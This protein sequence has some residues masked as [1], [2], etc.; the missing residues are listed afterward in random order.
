MSVFP[1][2]LQSTETQFL[3]CVFVPDGVYKDHIPVLLPSQIFPPV[4]VATKL[5]PL[6][7]IATELQFKLVGNAFTDH[8]VPESL[9]VHTFP[10]YM[11]AAKF[12]P[13]ESLARA[14]HRPVVG[15]PLTRAH[16]E[17]DPPTILPRYIAPPY[18]AAIKFPPDELMETAL[19]FCVTVVDFTKVFPE[20]TE[21]QIPEGSKTAT[22]PP[23]ESLTI[24]RGYF[25]TTAPP[26]NVVFQLYFNFDNICHIPPPLTHAYPPVPFHVSAAE[27]HGW[28]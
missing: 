18:P 20:L 23:E 22:L 21:I 27:L 4:T 14:V 10:P 24:D 13:V 2:A 7:L 25:G 8:V 11:T 1:V 9:D 26:L 6:A 15:A 19:Q 5:V 12:V 16:P 3:F 17:N 28:F